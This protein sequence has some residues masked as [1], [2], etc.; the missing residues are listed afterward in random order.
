MSIIP[1][2]EGGKALKNKWK[3][4]VRVDRI[5]TS[6]KTGVP[7]IDRYSTLPV[8]ISVTTGSKEHELELIDKLTS[9]RDNNGLVRDS[10]LYR[11][12]K[13][14]PDGMYRLVIYKQTN[15]SRL[16][17]K[18]IYGFWGQMVISKKQDI[19]LF[20]TRYFYCGSLMH[21]NL[22]I[23]DPREDIRRKNYKDIPSGGIDRKW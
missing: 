13:H 21:K 16:Q 1:V 19:I 20:E 2:E 4:Q 9:D 17:G 12:L 3:W 5:T 8:T 23:R 10:V 22:E 7:V 18:S 11:V 15:S 6:D 14:Q